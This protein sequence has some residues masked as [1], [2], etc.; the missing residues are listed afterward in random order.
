MKQPIVTALAILSFFRLA[1]DAVVAEGTSIPGLPLVGKVDFLRDIQPLFA[2]RC[3][4]CHGPEKQ[5]SGL[6]LDIKERAL[7]GCDSGKAIVPGRSSES[8]LYRYVAH[9]DPETK[10]PPKGEALQPRQVAF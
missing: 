2:D 8:L 7:S 4:S 3:Y 1:T 5:K 10:M 6:R 9:L